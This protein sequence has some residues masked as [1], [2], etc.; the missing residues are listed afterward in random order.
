MD[1]LQ[2]KKLVRKRIRRKPDPTAKKESP[3]VKPTF[4]H[5]EIPQKHTLQQYILEE[6]D[7]IPEEVKRAERRMIA[8]FVLIV[9]ILTLLQKTGD[10]VQTNLTHTSSYSGSAGYYHVDGQKAEIL[11]PD[12]TICTYQKYGSEYQIIY[13]NGFKVTVTPVGNGGGIST[14]DGGKNEELL[15]PVMQ[16]NHT[17]VK[18]A[19]LTHE[20]Y[21]PK[22]NPIRFIA[23]FSLVYGIVSVMLPYK[24]ADIATTFYIN[25]STYYH[26]DVFYQKVQRWGTFWIVTS[27]AVMIL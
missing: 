25:K 4:V 21:T 18:N 14:Y 6:N 9:V 19:M 7:K 11:C 3:P 8:W 12:G 20:G 22:V 27:L 17:D 5:D 24:I 23:F 16:A 1:E 2:D 15:T 13:P 10:W 26:S